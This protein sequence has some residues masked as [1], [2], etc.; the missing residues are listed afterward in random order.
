[1]PGPGAG[2]GLLGAFGHRRRLQRGAWLRVRAA[3]TRA[4]AAGEPAAPA[5]AGRL[6]AR[7]EPV[8]DLVT[9]SKAIPPVL[10][11]GTGLTLLQERQ[12]F[13]SAD[14]LSWFGQLTT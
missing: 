9:S 2:A 13:R 12:S 4:V 10:Q 6:R 1:M 3:R 14:Q 11:R 8:G 5:P 7:A